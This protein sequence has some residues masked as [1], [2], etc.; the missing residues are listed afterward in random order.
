MVKVMRGGVLVLLDEIG[1]VVLDQGLVLANVKHIVVGPGE[2]GR[3][4]AVLF[5]AQQ[6]GAQEGWTPAPALVREVVVLAVKTEVGGIVGDVQT[7]GSLGAGDAARQNAGGQQQRQQQK[8][9]FQAVSSS[10]SAATEPLASSMASVSASGKLSFLVLKHGA[11][12]R[13]SQAND[14]QY[15]SSTRVSF[16]ASFHLPA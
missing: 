15:S 14:T 13:P 7:G 1:E 16:R 5:D 6:H 11:S 2:L 9:E 10:E 12:A 8:H 4:A 3:V